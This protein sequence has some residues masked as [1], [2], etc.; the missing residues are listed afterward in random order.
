MFIS[1]KTSHNTWTLNIKYGLYSLFISLKFN[2][3]IVRFKLFDLWDFSTSFTLYWTLY[4]RLWWTRSPPGR[5]R[6]PRWRTW[7]RT[8]LGRSSPTR[9]N[10]SINLHAWNKSHLRFTESRKN[11]QPD[12]KHE[13]I[14][15]VKM[16]TE[17]MKKNKSCYIN[18]INKNMCCMPS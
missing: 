4:L 18:F 5:S 3:F 13:E 11:P 7:S 14:Y 6:W 16:L 8:R 2:Y 10:Q 17:L 15:Q 1:K 12:K 9:I